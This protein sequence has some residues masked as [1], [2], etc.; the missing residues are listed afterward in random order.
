MKIILFTA[1]LLIAANYSAHSQCGKNLALTSSKT[2]YLDAS[3]VLQKTEEERSSIEITKSEIVIV[4][5]NDQRKITGTI[6][7][8]TCNWKTPFKEG[9]TILTA[10]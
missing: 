1:V 10:R 3:G 2:E 9:R 7:F 6:K 8:D 5:G 4:P